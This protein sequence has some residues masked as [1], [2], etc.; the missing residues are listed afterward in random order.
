MS[1]NKYHAQKTTVDGIT[2]DSRK[3]AARYKELSILEQAGEIS[4]LRLQVKYELVPER[5]EPETIGPRGVSHPGKRLEAAR[6]YIAD[7]VYTQ[8]EKT[9]VED[10]KGVKTD[11]YKL[12]RAL[13]LWRYGIKIHET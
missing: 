6:Y 12:K 1:G 9:V 3:E 7:F 4:D 8:G 11:V 5:R 10:C 2:F 13:M